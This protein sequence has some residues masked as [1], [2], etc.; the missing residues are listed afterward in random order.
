MKY[1]SESNDYC[2]ITSNKSSYTIYIFGPLISSSEIVAD[3]KFPLLVI[4][5]A[6]NITLLL[7][8]DLCMDNNK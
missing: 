3:I 4:Q 6:Y 2:N 7:E 8:M 1:L 5:V